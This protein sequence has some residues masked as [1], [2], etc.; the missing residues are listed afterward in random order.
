MEQDN[1]CGLTQENIIVKKF[2]YDDEVEL[3]PEPVL[4]VIRNTRS[5]SK[6]NKT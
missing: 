4:P 3:T 2:V 1:G 6:K 5:R